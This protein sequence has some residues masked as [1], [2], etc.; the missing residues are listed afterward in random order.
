MT[1]DS[2]LIQGIQLEKVAVPHGYCSLW[3]PNKTIVKK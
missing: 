1:G 2:D 3:A